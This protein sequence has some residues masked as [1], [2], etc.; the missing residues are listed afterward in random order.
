MFA[1][2]EDHFD[3]IKELLTH[4]DIDVNA[5]DVNGN[6]AFDLAKSDEVKQLL[7]K[8]WLPKVPHKNLLKK[9]YGH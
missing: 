4:K 3:I 5:K 8:Y 6:T 7:K 9:P 1:S 2:N